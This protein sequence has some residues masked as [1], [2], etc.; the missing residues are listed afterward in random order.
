MTLLR[1]IKQIYSFTVSKLLMISVILLIPFYSV[2]AQQV[3]KPVSS[4]PPSPPSNPYSVS[5]PWESDI[6][7]AVLMLLAGWFFLKRYR[8]SK[9]HA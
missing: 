4:T 1:K 5:A 6:L 9:N 7:I 2:F 3:G 8:S